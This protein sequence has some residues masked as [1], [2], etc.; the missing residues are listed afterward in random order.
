MKSIVNARRWPALAALACAGVLAVPAGASAAP[1][2]IP[3]LTATGKAYTVGGGSRATMVI[4]CDAHATT[5]VSNVAITKCYTT[6]GG[7]APGVSLPGV[8]A[9]TANT[10]SVVPST[11]QVCVEAKARLILTGQEVTAPLHCVDSNLV[12]V[13]LSYTMV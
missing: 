1:I 8:E 11:Y 10:V 2:I 3:K 13:G 7:F 5:A 12:G 9:V 6:N 4:E